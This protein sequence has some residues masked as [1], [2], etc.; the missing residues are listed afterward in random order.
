M[1][2]PRTEYRLPIT[3]QQS[4][5][6]ALS[7]ERSCVAP[8][9]LES[10]L[11]SLQ[12]P[13]PAHCLHAPTIPHTDK[14]L[15]HYINGQPQQRIHPL[16]NNWM[17]ILCQQPPSLR[18]LHFRWRQRHNMLGMKTLPLQHLQESHQLLSATAFQHWCVA[19]HSSTF[20]A[21]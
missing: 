12:P 10:P 9:L 20:G 1:Q 14:A 2:L 19:S 4:G 13:L 15:R 6:T 11:A 17:Q 7:E 21:E 8:A 3:P 18:H 5:A 16:P